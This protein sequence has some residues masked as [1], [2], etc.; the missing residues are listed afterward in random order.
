MRYGLAI[1]MPFDRKEPDG[2]MD[3]AL[4]PF[5]LEKVNRL[6]AKAS[7]VH[8]T[9]PDPQ[10]GG[11]S[12]E[13]VFLLSYVPWNTEGSPLRLN[14]A[15]S[16]SDAERSPF[17]CRARKLLCAIRD[18]GGVKG[19]SGRNL[20][21]RFVGDM[22]R[23]VLTE[24]EQADINEYFKVVNEPDAFP[25]HLA[26]VVSEL[27]KLLRL[28]KGVFAIPR[29]KLL[30]LAPERA[31]E[32]FQDLFLA[33]FIK[34][35]LA[36]L[37]RYGPEAGC[38]QSYAGYTLYRLGVVADEWH[39]T[40]A[41]VEEIMLPAVR[42][43]VAAEIGDHSFWNVGDLLKHRII[44]PLIDW[45]LLEGRYDNSESQRFKT[46]VSVRIT[47]LFRDYLSFLFA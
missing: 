14:A 1:I 3:G 17:F 13:Q 11:L 27:A 19:T 6:L 30:L 15:L 44:I 33:Y 25:L 45:G 39:S 24:E 8:N 47:P 10:M 40:D 26:R 43:E 42:S 16:L 9:T 5:D 32:L 38:I 31:G 7:Q 22:M 34:F 12:P 37:T 35:N 21:R 41:L 18:A 23:M 20:N 36:Y 28:S 2:D 29:K 46:L 4:P